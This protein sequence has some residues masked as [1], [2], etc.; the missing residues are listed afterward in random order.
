MKILLVS[1]SA[2]G[3]A[4]AEAFARSPQNPEIIAACTLRDPGMMKLAKDLRVVDINGL[5]G[6]VQIAK[7]TKPDFAFI[8]PDDPIGAGLSDRFES[9][10]VPCVAP[11]KNLAR[12]EASK[13][14]ARNLM[15]K[16]GIGGSP[17]FRVFTFSSMDAKR[18]LDLDIRHYLEYELKGQYVVK[19]DGLKGGKGVKLSG[20]HLKTIDLGAKYAMECIEQC[21]TVVIEEKLVGVEFSLLSFV[22]GTTTVDMPAIQDYKRAYI[23]D[24]GLNTGGMGTYSD[25][26]HLLPFLSEADVK[27]A[28]SFNAQIAKALMEECDEPYKGILYGGFIA[29][30]DGVKI[31]EYN[32]R[33][34]DPEAL[35]IL[36]ILET[37]FVAI[38]QAIISGTLT[39]DLVRFAPLATVCKYITPRSYPE[40]KK[41]KGQRVIVPDKVPDNVRIY[42]GDAHMSDSGVVLLGTSRAIG[43]VGI[44]TT[45]NEAEELA[46]EVCEKISGPV[47]FR[48]DIATV[49]SIQKR[50][51][52][53][54]KLRRR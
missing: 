47:R 32:A 18:Q 3:H 45:I 48:E 15:Q 39:N 29:T 33:F 1:N 38:C 30:A 36:P 25:S 26:N 34:G 14:F 40:D 16:Y 17:K 50:V 12:I 20:E 22:S 31:I 54:Q 24:E 9:I 11:K 52:L 4:I 51:D 27:I 46:Q 19:Y 5:S 7:E 21:G 28:S 43:I 8:A 2:R 23:N 53:M 44:G 35:N 49:E 6:I 42:Y 13:G 41:E 10:G 37:D